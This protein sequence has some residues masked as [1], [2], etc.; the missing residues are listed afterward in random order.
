MLGTVTGFILAGTNSSHSL[1]MV[2]A[3]VGS[4]ECPRMASMIHVAP[5]FPLMRYRTRDRS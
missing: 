2:V 1:L 5:E 4:P 3:K